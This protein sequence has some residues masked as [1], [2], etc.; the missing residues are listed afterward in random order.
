MH[1][2]SLCLTQ[3]KVTPVLSKSPICDTSDTDVRYEY[4]VRGFWSTVHLQRLT[5]S[6]YVGQNQFHRCILLGITCVFSRAAVYR[7]ID[8]TKPTVEPLFPPGDAPNKAK[9][10]MQPISQGACIVYF[11]ICSG[12]NW[13]FRLRISRLI[14]CNGWRVFLM[15]NNR[16]GGRRGLCWKVCGIERT[17]PIV[18]RP[19]PALQIGFSSETFCPPCQ[20][21]SSMRH[22]L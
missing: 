12:P 17:L 10:R 7:R 4:V 18:D 3:Y 15:N 6:E 16:S 22:L 20:R 5:E 11:Y 13:I 14:F 9:R 19:L 8:R 2:P 21:T 1:V